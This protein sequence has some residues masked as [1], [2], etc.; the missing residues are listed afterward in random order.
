MLI[1]KN[2]LLYTMFVLAL[3]IAGIGYYYY[4]PPAKNIFG[5]ALVL[6]FVNDSAKHDGLISLWEKSDL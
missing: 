3:I 2:T 1:M 4:S 5:R 6:M